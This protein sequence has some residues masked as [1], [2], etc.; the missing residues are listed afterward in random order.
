MPKKNT[1]F[2][3]VVLPNGK[4][5][6]DLAWSDSQL[7]ELLDVEKGGFS[8]QRLL[9]IMKEL[10]AGYKFV[11]KY[12]KK[13]VT[14]FGSA[15]CGFDE[16]TYQD[17]TDLGYHLSKDGYAV[18]TGGG[19]GIMEAANKGAMKAG[20]RS[21]GLN[22]QLETEQRINSYVKESASFH[23][24]FTRKVMLASVSQVYVFF[25]GGFGTMDELFEMLTLVQTK[26]VSP[27]AIILVNREFWKPMLTWIERIVQKKHHAIS[28]HDTKLYYVADHAPMALR[29]IRKL[30]KE[31][32]LHKRRKR[33]DIWTHKAE[34]VIMPGSCPVPEGVPQ[35]QHRQRVSP[36]G[37][38]VNKSK[39]KKLK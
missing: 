5:K 6:K 22:I 18:V 4:S 38:S 24:F 36:S 8:P 34:G 35:A 30:A 37:K 13:A 19:P 11:S 16:K 17:A 23:Y 31:G 28:E 20:G 9:R 32:K 39:R 29:I 26:K 12:S 15:R 7:D 27:V 1:K 10:V 25:P 21:V 33:P 14:I 2:A 3:S